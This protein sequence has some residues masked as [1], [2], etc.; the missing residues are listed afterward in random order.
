MHRP[1][2]PLWPG[3]S[4]RVGLGAWRSIPL[5][6][7]LELVVFLGGLLVYLRT[8]SARDR[9][10]TWA[11]WSMV[12]VLLLIFFSGFVSPP[13]PNERGV[14]F[15]ALGLWLF[16]PWGYWIDRHRIAA[17]TIAPRGD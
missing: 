16:V 10:G 17:A 14:A 5:T 4:I 8:T 7:L 13:P 1:D 2:L 12:I 6:I 15:G 11:L 3:S 9:T